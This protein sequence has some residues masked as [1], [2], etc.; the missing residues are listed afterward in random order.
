MKHKD[1]CPFAQ[2]VVLDTVPG[3][4]PSCIC[5]PCAHPPEHVRPGCWTG[6]PFCDFCKTIVPSG[7]TS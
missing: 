7:A 4:S 1:G 6:A 5:G 2:L 3:W